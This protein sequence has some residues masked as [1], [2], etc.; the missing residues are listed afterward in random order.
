MEFVGA[1]CSDVVRPKG[2][3][4][5]VALARGQA[6]DFHDLCSS[7]VELKLPVSPLAE[8]AGFVARACRLAY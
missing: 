4:A 2:P 8:L 6:I 3:V 1:G 7:I 5:A